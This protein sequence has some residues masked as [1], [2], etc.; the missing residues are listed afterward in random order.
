MLKVE[1]CNSWKPYNSKQDNRNWFSGHAV[2]LCSMVV[3]G[4]SAILPCCIKLPPVFIAHTTSSWKT[5]FMMGQKEQALIRRHAKS[6]VSDQS[7]DFLSQMCICRKNFSCFLHNL[8]TL[9]EYKCIEKS[10]LGKHYVHLIKMAFPR[11]RHICFWF[12]EVLLYS[13]EGEGERGG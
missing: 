6:M 2:A 7:M 9:C 10:D 4:F 5:R 11:W 1:S 12:S 13:E 8:K 3:K